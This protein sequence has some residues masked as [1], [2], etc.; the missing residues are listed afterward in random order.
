MELDE[1]GTAQ[2]GFDR[3]ARIVITREREDDSQVLL[4]LT[5]RIEGPGPWTLRRP[6]TEVTVCATDEKGAPLS[7]FE[8]RLEG[9]S[10]IEPMDDG[11][12]RI[13]GYSSGPLRFWVDA[14]GRRM[15]DLRLVL[16]DGETR[17]V[18]VRLN[19]AR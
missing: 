14:P 18:V 7:E 11:V 1:Q 3:G 13:L 12:V 15:R 9:G 10:G 19:P 2:T 16:A 4:P 5:A 8:V 17:E 6:A